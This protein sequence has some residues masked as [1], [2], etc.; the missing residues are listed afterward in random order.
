M[1][2][3]SNLKGYNIFSCNIWLWTLY[4]T[5]HRT[6]LERKEINKWASL[7]VRLMSSPQMSFSKATQEDQE[8]QITQ[9]NACGLRV[10]TDWFLLKFRGV[11]ATKDQ[12]F[13][14]FC[15]SSYTWETCLHGLDIFTINLLRKNVW[16]GSAEGLVHR[17][18]LQ[19]IPV[20]CF[21]QAATTASIFFIKK[22]SYT[23]IIII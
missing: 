19:Q 5:W 3:P 13:L 6:I 14:W 2:T 23:W 12:S 20:L 1:A 10:V 15:S 8:V 18:K 21:L 17:P 11:S 4:Q 22:K 7:H 9:I 16:H